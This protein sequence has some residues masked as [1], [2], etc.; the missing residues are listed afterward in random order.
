[1]LMFH[2][3]RPCSLAA[4]PSPPSLPTPVNKY[5]SAEKRTP[6]MPAPAPPSWGAPALRPPSPPT[7]SRPGAWLPKPEGGREAKRSE[8]KQCKAEQSKAEQCKASSPGAPGSTVPRPSP[9]PPRQPRR[10]PC[11]PCESQKLHRARRRLHPAR[12]SFS[13]QE[14]GRPAA[15][16]GASPPRRKSAPRPS[17][18]PGPCPAG[19]LHPAAPAPGTYEPAGR[20]P[21]HGQTSAP[22]EAPATPGAPRAAGHAPSRSRPGCECACRGPSA[23]AAAALPCRKLTPH[24]HAP[25]PGHRGLA[26]RAPALAPSLL[27]P[28]PS[29]SLP[30]RGCARGRPE[31]DTRPGEAASPCPGPSDRPPPG[32]TFLRLGP[33]SAPSSPRAI[34]P[35]RGSPELPLFGAFS[36]FL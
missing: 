13:L 7:H 14:A 17:P 11:Y 21:A 26:A 23:R 4:L 10:Y 1:M 22:R 33:S 3:G 12:L 6:Q 31:T 32:L 15:G 9:S 27:S 25:P 35:P 36:F 5:R 8:E 28:S 20:L 19:D 24:P 34:Q 29:L 30:G 16:S 2:Q 18:G